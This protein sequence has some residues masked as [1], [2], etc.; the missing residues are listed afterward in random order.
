[1]SERYAHFL[2]FVVLIAFVMF[3]ITGFIAVQLKSVDG[4]AY[5]N[6]FTCYRESFNNNYTEMIKEHER[7]HH[8]VNKDR[9]HFCEGED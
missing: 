6:G 9:A 3:V 7:C 8:I 2:M 5:K 1:M 4:I